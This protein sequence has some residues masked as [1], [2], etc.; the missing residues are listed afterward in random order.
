MLQLLLA[1]EGLLLLLS[2]PAAGRSA[3]TSR[4]MRCRLLPLLMLRRCLLDS[5]RSMTFLLRSQKLQ[6]KACMQQ[7]APGAINSVY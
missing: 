4:L 3:G 5:H 1:D 2:G 6:V 7:A